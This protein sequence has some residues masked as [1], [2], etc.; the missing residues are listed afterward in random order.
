M[1]GGHVLPTTPAFLPHPIPPDSGVNQAPALLSRPGLG[2]SSLPGWDTRKARFWT[3]RG[4]SHLFQ[5]LNPR[6]A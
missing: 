6:E 3:P 5:V 1:G 4:S 2:N